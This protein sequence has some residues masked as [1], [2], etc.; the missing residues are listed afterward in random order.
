MKE[1]HNKDEAKQPQPD[2]GEMP[3]FD[4]KA[5]CK[6]HYRE[7]VLTLAWTIAPK[8]NSNHRRLIFG[9][10]EMIPSFLG[11]QRGC[12]EQRTKIRNWKLF[13][14]R[15]IVDVSN[16][17]ALFERTADS[18]YILP[19]F[20][21]TRINILPKSVQ[22]QT[23]IR[24]PLWGTAYNN[25]PPFRRT[26]YASAQMSHVMATGRLPDLEKLVGIETVAAWLKDRLYFN[27]SGNL[28]YLASFNLVL[29][30]PYYCHSQM[31]LLPHSGQHGE[32]SIRLSLDRDCSQKELHVRIIERTNNELLPS[33]Q[34]EAERDSMII[35]LHGIGDEVGV[36]MTDKWGRILDSHDPTP[37][38]RAFDLNFSVQ[39][40][41][42]K[43]ICRDGVPHN[44]ARTSN[45]QTLIA[46]RNPE[47]A[48]AQLNRK[49]V[50][51]RIERDAAEK[52]K[53]QHLFYGNV[54]EHERF[55]RKL[56]TKA[57]KTLLIIDPYFSLKT[58]DMYLEAANDNV[59]TK[60][61]CTTKGWESDIKHKSKEKEKYYRKL[62]ER[63][64]ELR[65]KNFQ[66]E[67]RVV[68]KHQ[69]HD[70]F[71]CIDGDAAWMLGA[72]MDKPKGSLS[73]I[74][75]LANGKG[76]N[77]YLANCIEKA[78][79]QPFDDWKEENEPAK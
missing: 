31:R 45:T 63:V 55:I 32:D 48:F 57:R 36:E 73:A 28:E 16:A 53:D 40:S 58:V 21:K 3:P 5:Y 66:I 42:K 2:Q 76:V 75:K 11:A 68:G 6:E 10:I 44:V 14:K 78:P 61:V 33:R 39:T 8:D 17:L 35:P 69:I 12:D 26:F 25:N 72:S 52:A 43:Y 50:D 60:I 19:P 49:L 77:K 30:N 62:K 54:G 15:E 18:G 27:L 65:R 9:L 37:F 13:F 46:D 38:I 71:I 51:L 41:T 23:S 24:T 64:D 1:T 29:P 56:V 47:S 22:G 59:Q 20:Q 4:L 79:G 7:A 74:V 67:I 34:M 70:R